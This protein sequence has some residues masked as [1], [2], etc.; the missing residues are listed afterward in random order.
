MD[1]IGPPGPRHQAGCHYLPPVAPQGRNLSED[2][3]DYLFGI[4]LGTELGF[5]M[6]HMTDA[7][8]LDTMTALLRKRKGKWQS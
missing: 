6:M 3:S 1:V 5:R 7:E 4:L 8:A 2:E